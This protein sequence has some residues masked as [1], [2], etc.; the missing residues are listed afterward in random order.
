M[1]YAE[2]V[3]EINIP[4]ELCGRSVKAVMSGSFGM[5]SSIIKQIKY[6]Q[7]GITVNG[8]RRRVNEIL[9]TGDF[10]RLVLKDGGSELIEPA[11]MD[12]D[13]IYEDEDIMIINKP[14]G[15]ATHPSQGHHGDTLA[16]GVMN[17]F[18]ERGEIRTFRAVNR[19]DKDTSGLI[20]IAKNC[21]AHSRLCETLHSE[22]KRR[23]IAITEGIIKESGTVNAPIGRCSDSVIKRCVCDDG[24]EAVT[25]YRPLACFGNY[26]LA[27]LE[28]HTGR[29][30]QI[31]VHMAH[32]G[33]PLLG[34]WLY[35][36]EDKALFPRP[37][38]HSAYM[39]LISPS[40]GKVLEFEA[41]LPKDMA[42]FISKQK[43]PHS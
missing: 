42:D 17:I 31:R 16:N 8:E 20:C 9:K 38:L 37:A 13:I 11:R 7:D 35:G 3:F 5:S 30:H 12:I 10:L 29:T 34:D 2:R 23:Y 19:L 1:R 15:T 24:R 14:P 33:H 39:R 4:P 18:A 21:Y 41:P 6:Y 32:I 40:N 22:L 25:D 26:T 28:L 36:T 43:A 27:E